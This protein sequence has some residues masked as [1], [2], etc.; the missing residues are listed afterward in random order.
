MPREPPTPI[1]A[2]PP[3]GSALHLL[4]GRR[5]GGLTQHDDRL[6]LGHR[7]LM[8]LR[9]ERAGRRLA[10]QHDNVDRDACTCQTQRKLAS[11][12][13]P[14]RGSKAALR[15]PSGSS[16]CPGA[17]RA[18]MCESEGGSSHGWHALTLPG[19]RAWPCRDALR[20]DVDHPRLRRVLLDLMVHLRACGGTS[21]FDPMIGAHPCGCR[22]SSLCAVHVLYT[23]NA[24]ACAPGRPCSQ[25][26]ST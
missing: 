15:G 3:L 8:I 26:R 25:R 23:C 6:G 24:Y 5:A 12:A 14:R 20:H 17:Q 10:C 13:V 22:R 16:S 9:G 11:L 18:A 21:C 2:L 19:R 1:P 7:H 4:V